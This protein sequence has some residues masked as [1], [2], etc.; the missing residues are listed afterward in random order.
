MLLYL[1]QIHD[2][3]HSLFWAEST[4]QHLHGRAQ[5]VG[6]LSRQGL[7]QYVVLQCEHC[8]K[9]SHIAILHVIDSMACAATRDLST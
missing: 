2:F 3:V 8:S 1:R 9:T 6:T 7:Y 4:S 5:T